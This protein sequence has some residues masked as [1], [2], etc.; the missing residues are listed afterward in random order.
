MNTEHN[1]QSEKK[2]PLPRGLKQKPL[3]QQGPLIGTRELSTGNQTEST[4]AIPKPK[5]D[6]VRVLFFGGCGEIGKNMYG[7]ECNDEIVILDCGMKFSTEDTLGVDFL[8]PNIQYLEERKD[9]VKGLIISH[10]H[11]DHIGGIPIILNRVGNPTIFSRRMSI[12]FIRNRQ[13]E[14]EM[15]EPI[16]YHEV[17]SASTIRLS[18]SFTLTFFSVTHTIP[19]AMGIII[20]TPAG[21]VVFTGDLKLKHDD[22]VVDPE[23]E[24]AFSVFKDKHILLTMADSTNADRSG[25]SLPEKKVVETIGDIIKQTTGRITLCLFSSQVERTM[26]VIEHAIAN[27]RKIIVQGRS[28]ITN[29]TIAFDLGLLNV[30]PN[31]IIPVESM[32]DF[33]KDKIL[34]LAT[35]AQGDNFTALD[36]MSRGTHR[37]IKL[38]KDDTVVFSSSIIPGNEEPVQNLKDRLSRLGVNLFTFQTSDVHS[39]GHANRDELQWIHEHIN[40][41]FFTPI[42][43]YHYM[44]SAHAQ[45]LEDIGMPPEHAILPDNGDIIDISPDGKTIEKYEQGM[46]TEFTVVDGNAVGTVQD[47]VLNDRKTLRDE[48]IFVIIVLVDQTTK[49]VRKS[50]DVISRGFVYLRESQQLINRARAIA[51][52]TTEQTVRRGRSINVDVL[53]RS[54]VR[55]IQHYLFAETKKQPIIIPVV[56]IS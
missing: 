6:G 53:K 54:L 13:S 45:I 50:P 9:M 3:R 51:R 26:H 56:F 27:G 21:S 25:F 36:R 34:I 16:T 55:D 11:L 24:Q 48:G 39:S 8:V 4:L 12:E 2:T 52:K 23:E 35:G 31:A 40:A 30:P 1:Q 43:G 37:H 19:D 17:E 32:G 33:P 18:D 22:G 10:A 5:K 15:K 28:M 44:L 29:M 20:D 14:F 49:R 47:V 46:P 38:D 42:H 7:L 41:R